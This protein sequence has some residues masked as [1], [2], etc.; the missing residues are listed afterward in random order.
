MILKGKMLPPIPE[1][2]SS[3]TR[4][5][6][7]DECISGDLLVTKSMTNL[8]STI[9]EGL[10]EVSAQLRNGGGHMSAMTSLCKELAQSVAELSVKLGRLSQVSHFCFNSDTKALPHC[11]KHTWVFWVSNSSV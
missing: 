5:L 2:S 3:V 6:I 10:S 11:R 7:V 9:T 4:S 1:I 8:A